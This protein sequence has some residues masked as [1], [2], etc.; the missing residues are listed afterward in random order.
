MRA[1]ISGSAWSRPFKNHGCWG[2]AQPKGRLPCL[3]GGP[4]LRLLRPQLRLQRSR[5]VEIHHGRCG[6]VE[7]HLCPCPCRSTFFITLQLHY[8]TLYLPSFYLYSN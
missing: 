5:A 2:V 8:F 3:T 7:A 1:R 6:V 4:A